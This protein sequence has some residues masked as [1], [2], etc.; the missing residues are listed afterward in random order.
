MK[1]PTE[2][3]TDAELV[4]QALIDKNA[5]AII[6]DRYQ[7][8]L[9]RYVRRLGCTQYDDVQDIVQ[10]VF[11]KTYY[12]LNEYDAKFPLSSWIYR[13][14][15]NETISF[16]RKNKKKPVS[17]DDIDESAIEAFSDTEDQ[18]E[19]FDTNASADRIREAMRTLD[20]KYREVLV[21]RYI[22][23]KTYEEISDILQKPVGTIS[24]LINRAKKQIRKIITT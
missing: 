8:K 9:A 3:H 14:T 2:Q 1:E 22:E 4:A 23:G 17:F 24:V 21:L 12:N 7:E 13:I 10:T 18:A 19:I 20:M 6:I 15:H 5:Y 16:F 11:I